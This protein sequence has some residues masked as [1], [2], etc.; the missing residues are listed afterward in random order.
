VRPGHLVN[1]GIAAPLDNLFVD[2]SAAN[3]GEEG[4][5]AAMVYQDERTLENQR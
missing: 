3:P 5:N 1:D 4:A 2:E